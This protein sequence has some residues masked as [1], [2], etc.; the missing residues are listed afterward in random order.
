MTKAIEALRE[1]RNVLALQ[2]PKDAS[3][4]THHMFYLIGRLDQLITVLAGRPPHQELH[5]EVTGL[6]ESIEDL[7]RQGRALRE[8]PMSVLDVVCSNSN[9]AHAYA[10]IKRELADLLRQTQ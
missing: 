3:D 8:E 2:L 6:L 1:E 10:K 4:D 5:F 9:A 7:E